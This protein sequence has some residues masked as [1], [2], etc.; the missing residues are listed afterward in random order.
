MEQ[1]A[2]PHQVKHTASIG[3]R[4]PKFE[5]SSVR[6]FLA[7]LPADQVEG[8]LSSGRIS[9][10]GRPGLDTTGTP[11]ATPGRPAVPQ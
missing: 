7:E 5:S 10:G 3:P 1:V 9:R 8:L 6:V 2:S 11:D 4:Y